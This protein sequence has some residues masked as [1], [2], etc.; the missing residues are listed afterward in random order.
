MHDIGLAVSIDVGGEP[1]A[2]RNRVPLPWPERPDGIR[3]VA[4]GYPRMYVIRIRHRMHDIG[5]AV[6][7]D[8]GGEP[9]AVRN[10]VPLPWPECSK[11][12]RAV[13]V[14]YPGMYVIRVRYGVHEVHSAVTIEIEGK[15]YAVG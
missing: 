10:R 1:D 6:S 12:I 4:V 8:V 11:G 3:A 15:P 14:G 13:A 9:D 2:V 5:L 7:I